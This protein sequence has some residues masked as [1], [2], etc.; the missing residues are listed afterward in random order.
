M[1]FKQQLVWFD[2]NALTSNCEVIQ[3]IDHETF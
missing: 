3:H 1:D 2:V